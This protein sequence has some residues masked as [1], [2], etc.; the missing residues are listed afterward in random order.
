MRF[1]LDERSVEV[2]MSEELSELVD[3]D[4]LW[5][6]TLR[7]RYL[8]RSLEDRFFFRSKRDFFDRFLDFL[9]LLSGE[10]DRERDDE[11]EELEPRRRG[12]RDRLRGLGE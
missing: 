10:R 3:L 8:F 12:S 11:E 6:L 1:L 4:S 2:D 9:L 7:S 5:L